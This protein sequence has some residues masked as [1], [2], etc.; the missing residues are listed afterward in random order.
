MVNVF[1][2]TKNLGN[3]PFGT[4]IAMM[5]VTRLLR[6][7]RWCDET[8]V[9]VGATVLAIQGRTHNSSKT[10]PKISNNQ[11]P[12]RTI[13]GSCNHHPTTTSIAPQRG[14]SGADKSGWPSGLM[15]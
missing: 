11:P 12:I 6:A 1:G 2:L 9:S 7:V 10:H 13:K 14:I 5:A 15:L 3:V 8:G 4:G